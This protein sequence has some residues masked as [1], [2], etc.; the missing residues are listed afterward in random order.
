MQA[1][2]IK[3]MDVFIRPPVAGVI[4]GLTGAGAHASI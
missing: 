2:A 1:N 4:L 3:G